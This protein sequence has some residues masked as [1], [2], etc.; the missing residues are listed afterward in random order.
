MTRSQT[1]HAATPEDL[2]GRRVATRLALAADN[3]PY[4]VSER[5]RFARQQALAKQKEVRLQTA[6]DVFLNGTSASLRQGSAGES[7]WIRIASVLPLIALVAG[8]LAIATVAEDKRTN[9]IASV[10]AEL[11]TDEL[12]PVAY[13]DPGFAQF[14][15][16]QAFK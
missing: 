2:F 8:L 13:T 9:D 4:E 15:R 1:P 11:L 14:L 6:P 3:L 7:L 16:A 10:D 5:L 12:P